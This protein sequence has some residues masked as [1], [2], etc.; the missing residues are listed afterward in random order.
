MK[1]LKQWWDNRNLA[2]SHFEE[3]SKLA[4][5]LQ[6]FIEASHPLYYGNSDAREKADDFKKM[7]EN[8]ASPGAALSVENMLI[9]VLDRR[10]KRA[11]PEAV[12]LCFKQMNVWAIPVVINAFSSRHGY[13]IDIGMR[14]ARGDDFVLHTSPLALACWVQDPLLVKW[15]KQHDGG[16]KD[17]GTPFYETFGFWEVKRQCK[18]W[19]LEHPQKIHAATLAIFEQSYPKVVGGAECIL[20]A[21]EYVDELEDSEVA[22][23]KK[24]AQS[25]E[26]FGQIYA[27]LEH[28]E[29]NQVA[30]LAQAPRATQPTSAW[31]K[32]GGFKAKEK[33]SVSVDSEAAPT[34]TRRRL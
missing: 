30:K 23:L 26:E 2:V 5:D 21:L 18:I 25:K 12:D 15:V 14:I 6:G 33:N 29:M 22:L 32:F 8:L 17:E 1:K 9:S 28:I 34:T 7:L 19:G 10:V 13:E 24:F 11:S 27:R 4:S 3:A 16:L 31:W 20:E